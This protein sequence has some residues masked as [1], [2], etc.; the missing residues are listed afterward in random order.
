MIDPQRAAFFA[1]VAKRNGLAVSQN[2]SKTEDLYIPRNATLRDFKIP[3]ETLALVARI[4]RIE[5]D[6]LSHSSPTKLP[7][8]EATEEWHRPGTYRV[9]NATPTRKMWNVT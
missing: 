3:A 7:P 9:N 1:R 2:K 5:R 6:I 4:D 8:K